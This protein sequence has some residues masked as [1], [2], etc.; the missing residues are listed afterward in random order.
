MENYEE[1]AE[2]GLTKNESKAYTTL[3]EFG[4]LSAGEISGK[5]GVSHSKIYNI[6]ESL[7]HKGLVKIIPE[8]TKKFIPTD[9]NEF[10][11]LI[12][13]K[14][15]AITKAKEKIKEMKKFYDIKEKNPVSLAYGTIGFHKI[16]DEMKD[17]K[18]YSYAIKWTS[19]V[20]PKWIQGA[21]RKVKRGLDIKTLVRFDKET[22]KNVNIWQKIHTK[23]KKF[24]NEGIAFSVID[25]EE[26]MIALIKSNVTLLIKDKPFAKVMKILFEA[27]YD[28]AK[29][30]K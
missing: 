27:A 8:K 23:I 12:E 18:E 24:P 3:I 17:E 19:E 29:P 6:L 11:K 10:I 20:R 7:I 14:E 30:I 2:L 16:V 21:K 22:E 4:K 13:K 25:D 1:F 15:K 9:P 26:V 5:S 28:K